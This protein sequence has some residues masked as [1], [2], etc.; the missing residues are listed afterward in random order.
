M[1]RNV[2]DRCSE[3]LDSY[4]DNPFGFGTNVHLLRLKWFHKARSRRIA[5]LNE[6][7]E[8]SLKR[9]NFEDSF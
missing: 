1:T 3:R 9:S 8:L 5:Q 7:C 6:P 4:L 2:T